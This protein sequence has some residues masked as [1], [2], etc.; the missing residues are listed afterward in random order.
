MR[1]AFFALVLVTAASCQPAPAGPA[2]KVANDHEVVQLPK[3]KFDGDLVVRGEYN[4]VVGA[5]YGKT[6][7]SGNLF[8]SG[9]HNRV[10][11][12]TVEGGG[13]ITGDHNNAKMVEFHSDVTTAGKNPKPD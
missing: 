9:H 4:T 5:G 10:S 2:P 8:M 3:G 1:V 11:S 6:V 12:V 7:I 13:T